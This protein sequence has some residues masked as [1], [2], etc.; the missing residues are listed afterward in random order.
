MKVFLST[1]PGG[2]IV[3][4][5]VARGAGFLGDFTQVIE[6]GADGMTFLGH[7]FDDLTALGPGEHSIEPKETTS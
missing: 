4:Q 1:T 7:T 3:V 5:A 2:A 6:P